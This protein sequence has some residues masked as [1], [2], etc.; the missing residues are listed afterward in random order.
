[1]QSVQKETMSRLD[2]AVVR[3]DHPSPAS[4][5]GPREFLERL[6]EMQAMCCRQG[7][8]LS[9]VLVDVD[10]F[11]ECNELHSPAFGDRVLHHVALASAGACR[12]NDIWARHAADQFIL[13]L[14]GSTESQAEAVV[15]RLLQAIRH[16][17]VRVNNLVY[18]IS[19]SCGIAAGQPGGLETEHEL[20]K[21]CL[22]S[23]QHA[24]REGGQRTILWSQLNRLAPSRQ[25]LDS[26]RIEDVS[27]W[28]ERI[29]RQLQHARQESTRVLVAAVEAKDP[30]TT[31]HSDTVA[32]YVEQ[33]ARR[34]Q[35]PPRRLRTL[36]TASILH[37]VG[38][39][40]VPDAIL[41]K[42]GPLTDE[43][44][45]IVRRHPTTGVEILSH[46][47]HLSE[48]LPLILHHHEWYDG[49]GYPAG[50]RG[51]EIPFGARILAA[52]DA[53]DAMLSRR[54]Y[55]EPYTIERAIDELR[56]G[57]GRQF[58]PLVASTTIEWLDSTPAE[59][60]QAT[61]A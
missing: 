48:E 12:S 31:R 27:L 49:K 2:P 20:I 33:I 57:T 10:R 8:P 17:P 51:D 42:P 26:A 22:T 18:P 50:L 52:A 7:K 1:V 30:F 25:T 13:G 58:D 54:S 29:R 24:Q 28:V 34:L 40:G 60:L 23:L 59:D 38:K 35:L 32:E 37:D 14:H 44:L 56:A 45:E 53:L 11:H 39:L 36:R 19:I 47:S 16:N 6:A 15:R 21:R 5:P 55:K 43:E 41:Q 4:W 9:V 46:A 3:Q 61:D